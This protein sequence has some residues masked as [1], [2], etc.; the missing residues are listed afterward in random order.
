MTSS[1]F[2][3]LVN[4]HTWE[5]ETLPR[6]FLINQLDNWKFRGATVIQARSLPHKVAPRNRF[7]RTMPGAMQAVSRQYPSTDVDPAPCA[8]GSWRGMESEEGE[9]RRPR[10]NST[11]G[12]G[13]NVPLV[14]PRRRRGCGALRAVGWSEKNTAAI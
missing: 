14:D 11:A 8:R 12:D 3:L 13:A 9:G 7:H 5:F 6:D 2:S 4:F 10:E 1:N